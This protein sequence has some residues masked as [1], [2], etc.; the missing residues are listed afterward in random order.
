MRVSTLA[1][2]QALPGVYAVDLDPPAAS[3]QPA[4]DW[5]GFVARFA[6]GPANQ[7]TVIG[8]PADYLALF[9]PGGLATSYA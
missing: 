7:V 4:L 8:T 6:W 1:E 5:V 9:A 3:P 2:A